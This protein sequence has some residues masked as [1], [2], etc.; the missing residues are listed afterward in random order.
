MFTRHTAA[1]SGAPVLLAALAALALGLTGC[2]SGGGDSADGKDRGPAVIAPGKPGEPA[3]TLS[4]E[5]AAKAGEDDTPNSADFRYIRMMITHHRQALVM[6]GLAPARAKSGKVRK[7]AERIST[8][9]GPEI[10]AMKGWLAVYAGDDAGRG[11]TAH[12]HGAMPGMATERQ[13]DRLRAAHGG[14]FDA[15][16]LK[17]MIRH[18]TGAVSMATELLKTGNNVKVEEMAN[19]VISQ[20]SA[21]I[22]RMRRLG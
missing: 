5:E 11:R 18:H 1:R 2:S 20:Q 14:Q 15:L 10:E 13:L 6:S 12:E 3:R 8:G 16:F 22:E 9:Q 17:L 4:A 19:E 21:E 7:L